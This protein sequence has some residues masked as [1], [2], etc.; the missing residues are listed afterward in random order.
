MSSIDTL[1]KNYIALTPKERAAMTIIEATTHRREDVMQALV[2]KTPYEAAKE[3]KVTMAIITIAGYALTRSI[4]A[5][6]NGTSH[7]AVQDAHNPIDRITQYVTET[8]CSSLSWAKALQ[9]IEEETG[10]PF[11]ASTEFIGGKEFIEDKLRLDFEADCEK[12]KCVLY[13]MWQSLD[14]D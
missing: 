9:E 6:L 11:I 4:L 12:Q 5:T 2:A 13:Q 14:V 1:R 3:G 7:A 8:F 10:M